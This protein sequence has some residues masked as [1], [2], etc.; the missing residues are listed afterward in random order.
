MRTRRI[1]WWTCILGGVAIFGLAMY[2]FASISSYY[3]TVSPDKDGIVRFA[4]RI[5]I[6]KVTRCENGEDLYYVLFGVFP[7][8]YV[9]ASGPPAYVFDKKG[10]LLEWVEDSGEEPKAMEKWVRG[11]CRDT[12]IEQALEEI[13]KG[14]DSQ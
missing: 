11:S 7:P 4:G 5:E 6:T 14:S 10:D 8:D 1:Q 12:T 9:L 3:R 2:Y 13:Q